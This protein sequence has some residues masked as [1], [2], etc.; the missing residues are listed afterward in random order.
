MTTL[1][2][3]AERRFAFF[4]FGLL[5]KILWAVL[6]ASDAA[7]CKPLTRLTAGPS[8]GRSASPRSPPFLRANR[9]NWYLWM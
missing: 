4:F 6:V 7:L 1:E 5:G 8:R 2:E 3:G 9:S